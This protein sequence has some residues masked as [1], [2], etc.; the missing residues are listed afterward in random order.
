MG[1]V[2][3]TWRC[4]WLFN[5]TTYLLLLWQFASGLY[6]LK[7]IKAPVFNILEVIIV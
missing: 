4:M 5:K 1:E 3:Y 2:E 6:F 7:V